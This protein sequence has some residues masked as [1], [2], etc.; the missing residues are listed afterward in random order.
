VTNAAICIKNYQDLPAWDEFVESHPY[1][2]I[3]HS[4]SM[5]RAEESTKQHAPYAIGA[6]DSNGSI[7][8]LLVAVRVSTLDGLGSQMSTRSIMYAEPISLDT[9]SG[10]SGIRALIQQHDSEMSRSTLFSEVR[11]SFGRCDAIFSLLECGY[12][13]YGY[14][15]Y[16]L[17]INRSEADLFLNMSPKRRNNVRSAV[18]RGITVKEL[19]LSSSVDDLYRL[20]SG[21]YKR[22]KVPCADV[23]LFYSVANQFDAS[24]VRLL[25]A[26]YEGEPVSAG[27]FLTYK[28]RV[29]CWYA[30][31]QRIQGV[32]SMTMVFWEAIKRFSQEGFSIF[33]LA[34]A[35]WEGEEYGPGKFKSKFGGTETNHG[36]FRKVYSPWKLMAANTAYQLIRRLDMYPGPSSMKQ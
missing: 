30:G 19:N 17:E 16:E 7:C 10:R 9:E 13:R 14:L 32:H 4:S 26:Y 36:R 28:D 1:G 18:R 24:C 27:C 8:A 2:S 6:V 23:S 22:S 31:T 34:G 12:Q 21:S 15:N 35:G 20:V 11:P 33:D 5:I 3:F 29:I 25:V